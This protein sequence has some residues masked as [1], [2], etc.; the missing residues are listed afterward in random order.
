MKISQENTRPCHECKAVL[1]R[2]QFDIHQWGKGAKALCH[3]CR[4]ALGKKVLD[5][6]GTSKIKNLPDGTAVC[7]MHSLESCDICMMDFI[8]P[9]QFARMRLALGRDLTEDEYAEQINASMA[10]VHI[11]RKICIMDGQP[12]CPR[13]GCK[14]RCPCNEVTYCS[15]ACQKHHWVIHKMTCKDYKAKK[16]SK[17]EKKSQNTV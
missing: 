1:P 14:L 4:D 5:S 15:K 3:C 10:D 7:F 9:N 13:S 12:I 17:A 6:I 2:N 8:L 16:D 11:S